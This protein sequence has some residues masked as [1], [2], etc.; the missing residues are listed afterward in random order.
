MFERYTQEARRAIFFARY[1]AQQ[2]GSKRIEAAHLLLGLLHD[3]Q[4]SANLLF[5]LDKHANNFR[6]KIEQKLPPT[7]PLPKTA[8]LGLSNSNKRVLAYTAE[9]ADQ[10]GSHPIDSQH[11]VLGLLRENEPLTASLLSEAGVE[12]TSAREIVE[13]NMAPHSDS[14]PAAKKQPMSP[15]AGIALILLL[16]SA[17]YWIVRLA[18]GR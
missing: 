4:S 18:L 16:L 14:A 7:E 6:L 13:H 2:F 11:L 10:L 15:V 5:G 9:E 1:E 8:E 12:L 3:R 17:I